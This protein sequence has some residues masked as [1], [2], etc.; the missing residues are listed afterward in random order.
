MHPDYGGREGDPFDDS[1]L[2]RRYQRTCYNYELPD[3]TLLYQQCRYDPLESALQR[4]VDA[5]KKKFLPRRPI[6]PARFDRAHDI[7]DCVIGAGDRLVIYNW[8]AI[9]KAGPGATVFVTEGEKN[10]DDLIKSGLVATTVISHKWTDECVAALTG[11]N[12]IILEDNDEHGRTLAAKS[13]EV[14][15]PVSKSTMIVPYSHLWKHLTPDQR[16]GPGEPPLTEDISDWLSRGGDPQGLTAICR[17]L[18]ADGAITAQPYVCPDEG[19][20]RPWD[21]LYGKHLLRATVSATAAMGA[22]GKSSLAIAEALAMTSGKALLGKMPP[23][24]LCVLLINLE[25]NR[26]AVDKRIVAA[27]KHYGLK[28]EDIGDRLFVKAKGE[29]KIKIATLKNGRA[30]ERNE[31]LIKGLIEF[32]IAN[33]IDVLS[34]DPFVKTHG[35]HENDSGAIQAVVECYDDIA[36]KAKCAVHLWHHT[37]KSG[38]EEASV[39]SARGAIAFVDACRS[40]RIL[41]TMTKNE[42]TKL[43]LQEGTSSRYF[44][45]FLGK[46]NFAPKE[47]QSTWYKLENVL[48]ENAGALFGDEVG[49]V[50]RWTHPGAEEPKLSPDIIQKI[51]KAVGHELVWRNYVTA[52]MWIGEAIAPVLDLNADA[53]MYEVKKAVKK[54]IEMNVLKKVRGKNAKRE[55]KWFVVAAER[56]A[57]ASNSDEQ[58]STEESTETPD[59]AGFA[60]AST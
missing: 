43:K 3:R 37:R 32:M 34:I 4:H 2:R 55:E 45:E 10:A 20:L 5:P 40:V 28:Q 6:D 14:L 31:A 24:P 7:G 57:P 25:D 46:L 12:L 56:V 33:K 19:D 50:T 27:M 47:D 54:L 15:A 53:D 11:Y 8:P 52:E 18:P 41:E 35:V 49:V 22:T 58:N 48:L 23:R 29:N 38:G 26:D 44:R 42:A 60:S 16:G 30:I 59:V 17:E 39:E 9:V 21:F 1:E 13:R 36:E 51:R